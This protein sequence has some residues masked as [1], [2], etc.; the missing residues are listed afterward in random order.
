MCTML[1]DMMGLVGLVWS[2]CA[3]YGVRAIWWCTTTR[4]T[5]KVEF[6]LM[7]AISLPHGVARGSRTLARLILR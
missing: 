4:N 1:Y 6:S 3:Y 2:G 5:T 7:G